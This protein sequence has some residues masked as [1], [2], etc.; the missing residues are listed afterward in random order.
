MNEEERR[1]LIARQHRALYG[2]EASIYTPDGSSSRPSQ[3]ARMS[4]STS[5]R[6]ASPLAFDS[7]GMQ[8]QQGGESAV[9]MP[10]RDM[11]AA[12]E[13]R[14]SASPPSANPANF[15]SAPQ[16]GR[17]S[18]SPTTTIDAAPQ[19]GKPVNTPAAGA[20]PIGTRPAQASAAVKRSTTPNERSA[21]AAS[22][23]SFADKAPG[24]GGWG[25]NSGVWGAPKNS[26]GVQAPVWG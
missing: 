14:P 4:T 17:T 2:N 24:F 19:G 26:Y 18:G 9:Q 20:V 21:S 5:V 16:V 15:E 3:D 10:P 11:A 22:N 8:S 1:D 23:P 7:F 13:R 6:G 12:S 25:S